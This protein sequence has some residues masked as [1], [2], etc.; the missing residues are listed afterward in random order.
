[1]DLLIFLTWEEKNIQIWM[2]QI[3]L[4]KKSEN[5]DNIDSYSVIWVE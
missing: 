2:M 4:I 1:M 3:D 5:Y